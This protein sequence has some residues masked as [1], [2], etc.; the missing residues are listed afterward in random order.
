MQRNKQ[1]LIAAWV[2]REAVQPGHKVVVHPLLPNA[3]TGGGGTNR[4]GVTKKYQ[5]N[6]SR[7]FEQRFAYR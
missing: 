7:G 4:E 3:V 2:S 5:D 1:L 6:Y